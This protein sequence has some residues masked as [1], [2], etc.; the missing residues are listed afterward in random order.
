MSSVSASSVSSLTTNARLLVV[1]RYHPDDV[2]Y[3]GNGRPNLSFEDSRNDGWDLFNHPRHRRALI[4]RELAGR[5]AVSDNAYMNRIAF[6]RPSPPTND[7]AFHLK[8]SVYNKVHSPG[9]LDF[10]ST[11]WNRWDAMGEE[12][13]DPSSTVKRN[14][15]EEGDTAV[16]LSTKKT[17]PLIPGNVSLPRNDPYQR[18]SQNV[19]GQVGYYC[20]DTCTPIF[21]ELLEELLWDME[22]VQMAVQMAV[23]EENNINEEEEEEEQKGSSSSK[24]PRIVYALCTHPGHHA[25]KDAYG[26]YCYVNHSALAARLMQEGLSQQQEQNKHSKNNQNPLPLPLPKVAVLDVDYHCGNGSASIFYDDPSVL[27]VSIHCH[28]DWDYPFHSGFED[29]RGV[30]DAIGTTLHLP[31]LPGTTWDKSYKATLERAMNEIQAFGAQGLVLSLGLDTHAGDPCAIRRAGF[32]LQGDDYK[33]MGALIGK[34]VVQKQ[35]ISVVVVQEG[36]YK[37]DK[38]PVAAADVLLGLAGMTSTSN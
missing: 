35:Q 9:L 22:T 21:A 5:S 12:G 16:L 7:V 10:L 28:P 17:L 30:G 14:L 18:P 38:V 8:D 6:V 23:S 2:S 25:A 24:C 37:M 1:S 31:L 20:T 29:E 13:Q 15:A 27:V 19:M 36:G 3:E 11:G 34:Y 26:G 32:L 4:L 33:E